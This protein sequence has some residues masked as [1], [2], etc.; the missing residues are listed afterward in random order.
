MRLALRSMQCARP[1]LHLRGP[2]LPAIEFPTVSL[3]VDRHKIVTALSSCGAEV[4]V[5]HV[6]E[7]CAPPRPAP[8]AQPRSVPLSPA[9][10]SPAPPR[11]VRV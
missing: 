8:P 3:H 9:Q 10:S 7:V 4:E 11:I 6:P 2:P 5:T 1:L